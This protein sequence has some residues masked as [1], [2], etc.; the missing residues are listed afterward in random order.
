VWE[1]LGAAAGTEVALVSDPPM[2][3]LD[4]ARAIAPVAPDLVRVTGGPEAGAE[5]RVVGA[6]GRVR[7]GAGVYQESARVA[8]LDGAAPR[9]IVVPVADLE[10]FG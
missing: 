5:G 10:R 6:A 9:E 3:V 8:V 2:L 7:G 4:A 1:I